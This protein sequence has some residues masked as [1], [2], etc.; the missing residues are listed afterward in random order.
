MNF[1]ILSDLVYKRN[2]LFPTTFIFQV[3]DYLDVTE[4]SIRLSTFKENFLPFHY[5][6]GGG[7]VSMNSI[8]TIFKSSL[9]LTFVQF[10]FLRG[11]P[12]AFK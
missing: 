6:I 7:A 3:P 8:Y 2:E 9:P 10:H 5:H 1:K 4:S 11:E 12:C